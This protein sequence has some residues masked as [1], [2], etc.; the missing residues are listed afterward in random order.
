MPSS[1]GFKEKTFGALM[2]ILVLRFI[3]DTLIRSKFAKSAAASC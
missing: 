2:V 1:I 3:F